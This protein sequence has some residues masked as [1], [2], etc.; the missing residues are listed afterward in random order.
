MSKHRNAARAY[1][2]PSEDSRLQSVFIHRRVPTRELLG[3]LAVSWMQPSVSVKTFNPY[4]GHQPGGG[5][6]RRAPLLE[7]AVLRQADDASMALQNL[8]TTSFTG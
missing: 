4:P 1:L 3:A 7:A 5:S 8:N 6:S 2:F